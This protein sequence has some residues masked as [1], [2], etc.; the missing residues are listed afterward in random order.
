M[1]P[2]PL[3]QYG[4]TILPEGDYKLKV[5][6]FKVIDKES[7]AGLL[8]VCDVMVVGPNIQKEHFGKHTELTFSMAAENA[9]KAFL[10]GMGCSEDDAPPVDNADDLLRFLKE[11]CL[12]NIFYA[13]ISA[14]KDPSGRFDRNSVENPW[15]SIMSAKLEEGDYFEPEEIPF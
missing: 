1:K 11:H 12:G 4:R 9:A 7:L 8:V 15:D 3:S 6:G 14:G 13:H 2:K 5:K 10:L